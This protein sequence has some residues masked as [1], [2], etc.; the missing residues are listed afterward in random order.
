MSV[1][2]STADYSAEDQEPIDADRLV[3]ILRQQN[4]NAVGISD[5]ELASDQD[6][7]MER[8]LGLPYG[9]EEEGSSSVISMDCAEVVDWAI[10]DLLEP[11]LAGDKIVEFE[12][13][14]QE[15]E[16]FAAQATD[17]CNHIW[18]VDNEGSVVLFDFVKTALIQKN[19]ILKVAW[20]DNDDVEERPFQGLTVEQLKELFN[21]PNVELLEVRREPIDTLDIPEEV[22]PAFVDGLAYSGKYQREVRH[23]TVRIF[24]VPPEQF[25]VSKRATSLESAAYCAHVEPKTKAELIE[26]GFDEET[27]RDARDDHATG[28][29]ENDR[30]DLRFYNEDETD[31]THEI[32]GSWLNRVVTLHEE[33]IRFDGKLLQCFRVGKT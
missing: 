9:D 26:L 6:S 28:D 11:F 14:R 10:P 27:V 19:G 22:A 15:D 31:G 3:T 30:D 20:E 5:D 24:S 4:D 32:D 25:R 21:D 1:V 13:T 2:Q 23:G 18:E 33:Y 16:Q 8:Y 12:A 29:Q 7:N 17:L